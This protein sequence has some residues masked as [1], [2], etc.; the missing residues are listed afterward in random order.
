MK[1]RINMYSSIV[2]MVLS[3]FVF[4]YTIRVATV[5]SLQYISILFFMGLICIFYLS[6]WQVNKKRAVLFLVFLVT[7]IASD[8]ING[9]SFHQWM[10]YF[11][12]NTFSLLIFVIDDS[13]IRLNKKEISRVISVYNFFVY[14]IF[15]IYVVDLITGSMIM[16]FLSSHWLTSI[17]TW[18]PKGYSL[19][20]SRYASYLGHY[21]FTDIIYLGFYI[22]NVIYKRAFDEE[23]IKPLVFYIISVIGVISTG[24]K[25]GL[26]A[27]LLMLI[28]F[29]IKKL[30]YM[31]LLCG[32]TLV[33]Y[34]AGFFNILFSRLSTEEFSTGR[35]GAWQTLFQLN[36]L[37]PHL[38]YGVGDDFFAYINR[39]I[40]YGT[41]GIAT[42]FPIL[43]M[44]FK[45]GI[46]GFL[47]Y[48]GLMLINPLRTLCRRKSWDGMICTGL[49]F[50]AIAAYNG[51]FAYPDTQI[52][53]SIVVILIIMMTKLSVKKYVIRDGRMEID[54]G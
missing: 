53:Y 20:Q 24:S 7:T 21:L 46:L 27:L 40:D 54:N 47:A 23:N 41:A 42:E 6:G 35:F 31:I 14:L 39:Y 29:N 34:F 52:V 3:I 8:L 25:T 13:K 49:L 32:G 12:M 22:L 1:I 11:F 2:L 28:L 48:L 38:F 51:L 15:A 17:V 4:G 9:V 50:F 16:R 44:F 18:V 5:S 10:L 30:K 33:L 19:F 36:V 37:K 45:V 26:L 43:C